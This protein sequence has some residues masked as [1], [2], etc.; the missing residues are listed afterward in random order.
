MNKCMFMGFISTDI[1]GEN[2]TLKDGSTMRKARFSIAC[3]RKSKDKTADFIQITAL[4]KNAENI[5]RFFGKGRG[6][7]VECHLTTGKYTNKE[8]KT[9][10]TSDF[11][12]DSFEFI[13]VRRDEE[14]AAAPN[15]T[16]TSESEGQ[17]A[18]N[19]FLDNIPDD[20]EDDIDSLPFK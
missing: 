7:Y 15:N 3:Q 12:M 9:I 5:E 10:F 18:P 16:H 17:P 11:V 19:D 2:M 8:G 14:Q 20:L 4:G 6:I 13:P 1:K